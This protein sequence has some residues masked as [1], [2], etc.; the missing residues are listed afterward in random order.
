MKTY[1]V[2]LALT[3]AL[4]SAAFAADLM[5]A[6][7]PSAPAMSPVV[8][9][10]GCYVDGGLG[11]NV[12]NQDHT[13]TSPGFAPL[14]QTTDGGRNWLGRIG[15]GCDY[16]TPWLAN[17]LVIGLF[18]DY[19]FMSTGTGT[20]TPNLIL[21]GGTESANETER[22]AWYVGG[23]LGYLITPSILSYVDGGYTASRFTQGPEFLTPSG[24][25]S[26]FQWQNFT[27]NGWFLGGGMETPLAELVPG[28]PSG[29]FLRTEYRY[30]RYANHDINEFT[31]ATG[32]PDGNVEHMKSYNQ[33]VTTSLI[34]RFNW[35]GH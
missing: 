3:G 35:S 32:V 31:V 15:G 24:A 25:L 8:N 34:W 16:Q 27:T 18:G 1:L 12:W 9:W 21:P 23:R 28:L 11:F 29:L 13:E 22:N 5:P 26:G 6:K 30:S 10:T 20:N 14:A 19:D 2:A 17:K 4:S 33:T 7:A